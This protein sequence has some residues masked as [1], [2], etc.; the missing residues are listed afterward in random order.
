MI[1]F[2]NES[3]SDVNEQWKKIWADA[4]WQRMPASWTEWKFCNPAEAMRDHRE[5]PLFRTHRFLENPDLRK[6][7][8][9]GIVH[10]AC[11]P[12]LT[13]NKRFNAQNIYGGDQRF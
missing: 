3:L 10:A 1:T 4:A 5:V 6:E 9:D 13:S 11:A 12:V 2:V 8:A 7:Q